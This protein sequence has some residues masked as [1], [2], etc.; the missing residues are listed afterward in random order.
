MAI[1]VTFGD[2]DRLAFDLTN[3]GPKVTRQGAEVLTKAARDVETIGAQLVPVDT[4]A[5]KNSIGVDS[6]E[7]LQ[8]VIGPTT[9]YAPYLELGT[10]RMGPRAFMGPAAD[11]VTP[12]LVTAMGQLGAE[13]LR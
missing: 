2:L 6:P 1:N 13:V 12:G 9:E 11:R 4:G 7:P 5:T 3:A 8:R 10:A